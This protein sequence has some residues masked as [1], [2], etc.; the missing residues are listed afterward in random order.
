MSRDVVTE[1]LVLRPLTLADARLVDSGVRQSHWS[2][3]YPTDGDREI[4]ALLLAATVDPGPNTG[5]WQIIERSS[6][7]AIGGIGCFGRDDARTIAIGYGLASEYRSQG[8]TTEA[9]RG[10]IDVVRH[11]ADVDRVVADTTTDNVASQ[12]VL[13]KAGFQF[14]RAEG[15]QLFYVLDLGVRHDGP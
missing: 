3:G 5:Q 12:R 14:D 15:A 6:G 1:R 7:F 10:L 2:P 4:A 11:S 13:E 9:V 8:L